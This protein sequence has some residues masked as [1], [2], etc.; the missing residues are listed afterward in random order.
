MSECLHNSFITRSFNFVFTNKERCQTVSQFRTAG[1]S[2]GCL[3]RI[4][5]SSISRNPIG[6]PS[7]CFR[8][9]DSE[10]FDQQLGKDGGNDGEDEEEGEEEDEEED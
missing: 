4:S 9:S 8:Y 1:G 6:I 10:A 7:S 5:G 3:K 2:A